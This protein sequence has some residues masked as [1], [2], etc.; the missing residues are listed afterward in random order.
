LVRPVTVNPQPFTGFILPEVCLSDTYAQFT[1]TSKIASGSIVS[2]LWNF[3]DPGSGPLNTSTLQNP[4]HSY[5]AVGI[6]TATLTT[7]SNSGCVSTLPQTFTVNG[8]IPVANF[9]ALN[10]ATMC[11]NDSVSIQDASTVNFGSVTKVEIYWDNV[12]FPAVLQTED[13]P[14][15]GKIYKH[16]YPNFQSPLTKTFTIRYRAYSGATCVDDRIKT[17]VVNAAPKVQFNTL[18]D[19]CLDA[20]PYQ[21]TQASEIGGVPGPAGVFSGPGVSPSGI[22]NPAV[23]GPGTY[24]IKYTFTSTAGGCVDTLSRPITV[25]DSAS[26]RFTYSALVCENTSVD[27]NSSIST[28]P[29][30]VGTIT[31]WGWD[32]G[33]PASGAANISTSQNPSH[34][35]SGWGNYNVK[36]FVTTSNGCKSTVRTIQVFVNPIPRP[37]F[38]TPPNSCLPSATVAFNSAVSSIPDGSQASFTYLWDFG[39][40]ASGALNTASGSS[41]SHIYNSVGPFNVNLQIT[42]G[43][44]CVANKTILLTTVRPQ[45]TGSFTA[46]KLDACVGQSF[47]FT[48]NSNPAGGS[49]TQ[50]SWNMGNA[51]T[52]PTGSA[53]T[54]IYP[55]AG[56]YDVT[57]ITT[58]NF[59]CRSTPATRTV[60]VNPYP[61]VNAGVNLFILEGGSDTLEPIITNDINPTYLW[62]PNLY[63]LGSNTIKN[64]IVKGVEDITYTLIVTGRGG[65]AREDQVFIKV[66][67]GPEI[68]NIFSPNGDGVHDK[69]EIKY[70]DTYPGGTVEIFNRYG[71]MIFRSVGYGNP[72]DGTIGGKEVPIGTYYYIVNPKNG[73]KIMSGYVDVIR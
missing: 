13:F 63:F 19:I 64:P 46:N 3:G 56:T 18:P 65:C 32:F 4:Q 51:S 60:T 33:D 39:D 38:S 15:P 37:D 72:W 36:L 25:L 71:Q 44:G 52:P 43:A 26:A 40:P 17:I 1:D 9:N 22:F 50:W 30:G 16:L 23:V 34:L 70:L 35:F 27:F 67:K 47:T 49:T 62:T 24:L 11:A 48:D 29:A 31:G 5:T 12:N 41:P 8:D 14:T 54:Y 45:P 59:G 28:I 20:T 6:Y 7:I 69:W 21:I 10:P 68:P 53:V 73:R 2:W 57:L 61:V 42:S 55:A 58:N 66:L